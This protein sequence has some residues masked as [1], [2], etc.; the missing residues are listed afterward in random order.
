MNK[1][2]V[3]LIIRIVLI[4]ICIAS[5]GCGIYTTV[6]A[7]QQKNVYEENMKTVGGY[8]NMFGD[9]QDE[10]VGNYYTSMFN[11][12]KTDAQKLADEAK[13]EQTKYTTISAG[14]YSASV[15]SLVASFVVGRKKKT[16]KE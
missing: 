5:L 12:V 6:N 9:K 7:V 3:K 8:N 16:K 14:L 15:V 13:A 11:N 10:Q 4:V 1:I 2:N